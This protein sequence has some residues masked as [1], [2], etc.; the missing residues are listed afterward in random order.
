MELDITGFIEGLSISKYQKGILYDI[1]EDSKKGYWAM[2]KLQREASAELI[3]TITSRDLF[4]ISFAV[5]AMH[6]PQAKAYQEVGISA[7]DLLEK[8]KDRPFINYD[9]SKQ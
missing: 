2:D 5:W 4:A 1:I 3:E 9:T 6:N 8:Y 7:Y